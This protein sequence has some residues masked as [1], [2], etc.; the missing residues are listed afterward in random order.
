[1]GFRDVLLC[2]IRYYVLR[3]RGLYFRTVTYL[4]DVSSIITSSSGLQ[5][6]ITSSQGI[7]ARG[8][9]V[10]LLRCSST[11]ASGLSGI[12]DRKGGFPSLFRLGGSHDIAVHGSLRLL[13][14]SGLWGIID[15]KVISYFLLIFR[16]RGSHDIAV[17]GSL[18]FLLRSGLLGV[19]DRKGFSR[20]LSR[21]RGSY[22]IA[23]DGSLILL[24]RFSFAGSSRCAGVVGRKGLSG[25]WL[26]IRLR[27]SHGI[28]VSDS[29][30]LLFQRRCRVA[31]IVGGN[32]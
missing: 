22:D 16:F 4:E 1:M 31:I 5:S 24:L 15:R 11:G 32:T 30:I 29:L 28:T 12:V 7:T 6:R 9:L 19:V 25:L 8:S 14:R 17:N 2:D 23:V 10:L 18:M 13:L 21:F 3:S 20:F 27:S 26:K